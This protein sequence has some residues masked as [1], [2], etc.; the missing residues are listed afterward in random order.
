MLAEKVDL[1][2][3]GKLALVAFDPRRRYRG[4]IDTAKPAIP[5]L[6]SVFPFGWA[7]DRNRSCPRHFGQ[8]YLRFNHRPPKVRSADVLQ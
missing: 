7:R 6:K 5:L 2:D 8:P 4:N 1:Y 3:P